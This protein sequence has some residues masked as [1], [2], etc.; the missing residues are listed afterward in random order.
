VEV[1]DAAEDGLGLGVGGIEGERP[2]EGSGGFL[3]VLA[4]VDG[5][6]IVFG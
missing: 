6:L 4:R 2:F 1:V 5:A 3:Q